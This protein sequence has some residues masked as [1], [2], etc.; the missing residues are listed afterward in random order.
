[1]HTGT[2]ILLCVCTEGL[3]KDVFTFQLHHFL[4]F[5]ARAKEVWGF[6]FSLSGAFKWV[7]SMFIIC[8]VCCFPMQSRTQLL[9][10]IGSPLF[11]YSVY[12][13]R[14]PIKKDF[15]YLLITS[16]KK[17]NWNMMT[18]TTGEHQSNES[19]NNVFGGLSAKPAN[20]FGNVRTLYIVQFFM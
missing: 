18:P 14:E 8:S 7:S 1:M 6:F 10:D 11:I 3:I 9:A 12:S 16:G 13:S 15:K 20:P 2:F 4:F 5:S 19:F 17:K